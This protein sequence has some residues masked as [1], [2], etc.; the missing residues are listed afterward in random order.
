MLSRTIRYEQGYYKYSWP[1]VL[2][3]LSVFTKEIGTKQFLGVGFDF[4]SYPFFIFYFIFNITRIVDRK[5]APLGVLAYLILSSLISI[6]ML[7]MKLDGFLKDIIP[8]VV[9]LASGFAILKNRSI[10]LVFLLYVKITYWSAIFGIIQVIFSYFFG[11]KILTSE[12][13]RLDSIAYEPSHYAAILMP[14]LIYTYINLKMFKKYFIVMFLALILTFNLTAYLVFIALFTFASFNPFYIL[15]SVPAAYFLFFNI[16]PNLTQNFNTR[17]NDTFATLNGTK[18]ILGSKLEVNGTTMSFFSNFDVA[19]YS[20][21]LNPVTGC[22]IGGHEEMYYRNFEGT[23]FVSNY[24]YGLNAK[25]GHSL[26]IRIL[27]E[28]GLVGMALYIF[29]LIRNIVFSSKGIHFAISLGCLGHFLCK[30]FKLGSYIDYGTPFFFTIFIL[31]AR[32]YRRAY[33]MKKQKNGITKTISR[34]PL[35]PTA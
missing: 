13:G 2:F 19:K 8:I 11:I 20:I 5:T 22:G 15:I 28:L 25:S 9:I 17:F 29:T 14:A 3:V 27:S 21:T 12:T 7:N 23:P 10:K 4:I 16:L 26:S 32:E 18:D 35:Q 1:E 24:Y 34:L 33:L 30:S 6:A 31:N